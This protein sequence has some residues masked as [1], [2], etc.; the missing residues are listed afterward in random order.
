MVGKIVNSMASD[1]KKDQPSLLKQIIDVL[2]SSAQKSTPEPTSSNLIDMSEH[3]VKTYDSIKNE[4]ID[5]S[6]YLNAILDIDRFFITVKAFFK[7]S[8]SNLSEFLLTS[9]EL[10][11]NAESK[12]GFQFA[13]INC[14][15]NALVEA[16]KIMNDFS[17]T[18]PE[19]NTTRDH[20]M[21]VITSLIKVLNIQLELNRLLAPP[22]KTFYHTTKKTTTPS[23]NNFRLPSPNKK[24][25]KSPYFHISPNTMAQKKSKISAML[26]R[27]NAAGTS[28]PSTNTQ[29]N[30]RRQKTRDDNTKSIDRSELA[31]KVI[32][33]IND[34]KSSGLYQDQ[35][36]VVIN[37]LVKFAEEVFTPQD[38]DAAFQ[39]FIDFI[40]QYIL[41]NQLINENVLI[42]LVTMRKLLGNYFPYSTLNNIFAGP[43]TSASSEYKENTAGNEAT[44]LLKSEMEQQK[45]IAITAIKLEMEQQKQQDADLIASLQEKNQQQDIAITTIKLEMKQQKQQDADL[46]ASL[47]EKNQQQDIAITTIKLE[48]K[49]QKQQDADLIASL[50][51]KNQQQDIAIT[52]IKLEMEKERV[53]ASRKDGQTAAAASIRTNIEKQIAQLSQDIQSVITNAAKVM[54][55]ADCILLE[56][57][58]LNKVKLSAAQESIANLIKECMHS[59]QE[60]ELSKQK[61]DSWQTNKKLERSEI[62]AINSMQSSIVNIENFILETIKRAEHKINSH[63]LK[64]REFF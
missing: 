45:D 36:I 6:N 44:S 54:K 58:A 21:K 59:A 10:L 43:K 22:T 48:M 17:R 2:K 15:K 60:L 52:T 31:N 33:L 4:P 19:A 55:N 47:Q 18:V 27:S 29:H 12:K 23:K 28:K 34:R 1:V 64:L 57:P 35:S 61:L 3:M 42:K 25:P 14:T 41:N 13:S 38:Q 51:E 9:S 26:E 8:F 37:Q 7:S 32:D 62:A 24:K 56:E 39:N 11:L 30:T 46:I 53:N 20:Q 16:E 63:K 49:Q 5:I 50:Q 40:C